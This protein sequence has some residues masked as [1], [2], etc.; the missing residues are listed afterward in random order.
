MDF[1]INSYI[2]YCLGYLSLTKQTGFN[3]TSV[4]ITLPEEYFSLRN[5]LNGDTDGHLDEVV[6]LDC[7]YNTDPKDIVEENIRQR[8]EKEKAFA[9]E[10]ENIY[11]KFKNDTYTKEIL[12]RFGRFEFEVLEEPVEEEGVLDNDL[13]A[14]NK[15]AAG[16]PKLVVKQFYL[17]SLPVKVDK[18]RSGNIEKYFITPLD[19]EIRLN[20][21]PLYEIFRT[22][23]KEDLVYEFLNEY[24]KLENDGKFSIPIL[25]E[26]VFLDLWHILKSK[27]KLTEANFNEDSFTLNDIQMT[28]SSRSNFFLVEDLTKLSKTEEDLLEGTSLSGWFSEE[29]LNVDSEPCEQKSLY[30]PFPY[31]KF[32]RATTSLLG[33]KASIIQGPP[34]T[35]KSE[36]ISNL[37]THL[38]AN[39]NRV[40][41][42]SQ[43]PQALRV[44]KDK[45]KTL[46]V[47][48]LFGYIPSIRADQVSD[49]E[50]DTIASQLASIDTFEADKGKKNSWS[51]VDFVGDH[52]DLLNK[53]NKI[54]SLEREAF[55]LE[56]KK[57][58][59]AFLD[60]SPVVDVE[61]IL[62]NLTDELFEHYFT[63]SKHLIAAEEQLDKLSAVSGRYSIERS[64]FN[65][66]VFSNLIGTVLN[67]VKKT[68]FDRSFA[69]GRYLNNLIRRIR[70]NPELGQLPREIY[71]E[72]NVILSKDLSRHEAI[73]E[74][75]S[76][77][78]YCLYW[79]TLNNNE[80]IR[81][82]LGEIEE[83]LGLSE[84][85][86]NE[87]SKYLNK[88]E[89]KPSVF[90]SK[91]SERSVIVNNQKKLKIE[92]ES[93]KREVVTKKGP[94][95]KEVV[96]QYLS[97][98]IEENLRKNITKV[99][100]FRKIQEIQRA[101]KK[102]KKA[103][104][105]FDKLKG[106]PE[107]FQTILDIVP[108]WIMDLDDASRLIP[109][110]SGLFDYVIFDEASQ[111]NI[112]YAMPSMYRG[113][114]ALFVGD[115]EQMRDSTV[116][117][118][119][120]QAF[121]Q[122]ATRYNV[123]EGL[124]IKPSGNAVQSVLDIAK[125]RFGIPKILQ[126]HYRSPAELIG[127]SNKYFYEPKGKRLISL[128]NK[129]LT[130][131][132]T[133]KI[134]VI[135]Q[136]NND[137]VGEFSDNTNLAEAIYAKD[138]YLELRNDPRTAD[139]SVGVLTFFND[140][141]ELIRKIFEEN[142]IKEDS[143]LKIAVIE[144]IQ[145]DEKDIIIYSFVIREPGQK[146]QYLPLTG[147]TGDIKGSINAGRVNVAFSRAKMQAHCLLST[148]VENIPSGIWIKKYL[149]YVKE[150]GEVSTNELSLKP[151][152]SYFEEEFYHLLK[153]RLG[154]GY[155]IQNQVGSCGF[156]IDFVV[157]NILTSKQIAIECDGPS[158]FEDHIDEA[159]GI[160]VESDIQRQSILE[161]AGW[162]FFRIGYSEW[163]ESEESKERIIKEFK[164]RI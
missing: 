11:S 102:S 13:S 69:L 106:N 20:L 37:I 100:V 27:L 81:I 55:N 5:L 95:R 144:G 24:V 36:T 52:D 113:K 73:K 54:I 157:T 119:S 21:P 48:L 49:E 33:N 22:Y 9:K 2:K 35:G 159:Y 74:L 94:T 88:L 143:N 34:G 145:G 91:I 163:I 152:D 14:E 109:L 117:F 65:G 89:L 153:K 103:F 87:L 4:N 98:I 29:G 66:F 138:L 146:R 97:S 124:Q 53:R 156:K 99:S 17:F 125:S 127:F 148:P 10:I 72:I 149:E 135:H 63:L 93:I 162:E 92:I 136:T 141:A 30:F 154:K 50:G 68:G 15:D 76:L 101:F 40:L 164:L 79:E 116:I 6:N 112:A 1:S 7:Y 104:K 107:N 18:E 137:G 155:I 70:L 84:K 160:Y 110:V 118:K 39:R 120:N 78:N 142:G 115:P 12:L 23:K 57:K 71:E 121:E 60:D 96:S 59:Y 41:F 42:V 108:V 28:L 161:S 25:S 140:Q 32:Q 111:C 123:P 131:K 8:Y 61:R 19:F 62:S 64:L 38:A 85:K 158:H 82:E 31:D 3:K 67:D 150:Y 126:Y 77:Q 47:P 90:V 56:E 147:E 134:M 139:K 122:L 46:G 86:L 16:A 133:N 130:Y 83:N 114:K 26:Q 128:N 151:F 51:L 132:D 58:N 105:T 43:K 80:K 44:V 75:S 129:Y 45:L